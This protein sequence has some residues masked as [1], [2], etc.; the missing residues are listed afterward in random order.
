MPDA[1][2]PDAPNLVIFDS[3]TSRPA[4]FRGVASEL[5]RY[6]CIA[7]LKLSGWRMAGDWPALDKI[8]LVAAPHTSNWDG[9]NML[10]A[11][12]YYRVTLNWMGKKS[13]TTGP[14]GWIIKWLGCVPIDRSEKNDLVKSM[15]DAFQ[16]R[17]HMILAIPPEGTRS[18][19]TE[20]KSGFYHIAHQAGVP[21]LL[22][23]LDYG[24]RTISVRGVMTPSG[25]YAADLA[26]IRAQYQTAR[27]K[28]ANQF[29]ATA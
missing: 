15:S 23:V 17:Q 18:L 12:G 9:V 1:L 8:V 5:F 14:F 27:G 19:A 20:W 16:T 13:L 26:I 24:T 6:V 25:D 3:A 4:P 21:I 28:K 10:A 22:T 7:Y 2:V 29:S 11:A